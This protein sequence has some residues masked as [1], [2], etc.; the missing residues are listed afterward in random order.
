M[1]RFFFN[2]LDGQTPVDEDG[3]EL[4]DI[5]TARSEAIRLCG[6]ILREAGTHFGSGTEWKLEVTDDHRTRLLMLR[7]SVHP[8]SNAASIV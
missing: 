1:A 3:T 5:Y 8:E 4:P 2:I 6:E 7:F